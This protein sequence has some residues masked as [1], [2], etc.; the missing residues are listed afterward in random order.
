MSVKFDD[1]CRLFGSAKA[2]FEGGYVFNVE[3]RVS[4][5]VFGDFVVLAKQ[6]LAE[7]QKDVAADSCLWPSLEDALK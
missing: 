2:D 3:F 7:G 1:L 5:E 6:C 4:G